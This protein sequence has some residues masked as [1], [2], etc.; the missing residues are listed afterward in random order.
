MSLQVT[1][2]S[3]GGR[4]V[5]PVDIRNKMHI[6]TGDQLL[7]SFHNGEI[8]LATKKQRLKRSQQIVSKYATTLSLA[9]ELIKERREEDGK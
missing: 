2:V 1:Q 3:E 4:I 5:I 8:H 7:V 9:D 6:E